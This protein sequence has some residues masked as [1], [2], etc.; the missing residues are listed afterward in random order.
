MNLRPYQQKAVASILRSLSRRRTTLAVMPTGTGKTVVFAEV[1]K[2]HGR[3]LVLAHRSELLSQAAMKLQAAGLVV[4]KN[5]WVESVQ[6]M[7][8][9]RRLRRTKSDAF[10]LV[11]VD[12]A[13]HAPAATYRKVIDH[14]AGARVLGVTAT[15]NRLD[16]RDI[17][18]VFGECCFQYSLADAVREGWLA[19]VEARRVILR[20][21]DLSHVKLRAGD[22][23]QGQMAEVVEK[24][25]AVQ[26]VAHPMLD[27][28][29]H[30]RA[31]LFAT[32]VKHGEALAD[33]M[34]RRTPADG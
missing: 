9:P 21:V 29:G 24:A 4:G 14:F 17:R 32:S 15:P 2:Q 34:N 19:S 7:C 23:D 10:D 31:I 3:V 18:D 25:E 20:D 5:A 16:E 26:G 8:Q 27:L 6:A 11:I 1:A 22:L 28:L 12:E 30:R 13:H 33:A